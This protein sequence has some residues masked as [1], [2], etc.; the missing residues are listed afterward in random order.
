M[1]LPVSPSVKSR[2]T[3]I[4]RALMISGFFIFTLGILA[5]FV[6]ESEFLSDI[7]LFPYG[8]TRTEYLLWLD[9]HALFISITLITAS[10]FVEMFEESPISRRRRVR[11]ERQQ[12]SSNHSEQ[13]PSTS[14]VWPSGNRRPF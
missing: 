8:P 2:A 10:V 3:Q 6:P 9:E 7:P 1:S 11:N 5:M 12:R 14:G 4:S 13:R